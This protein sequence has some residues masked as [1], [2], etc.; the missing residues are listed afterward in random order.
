VVRTGNPELISESFWVFHQIR[1]ACRWMIWPDRSKTAKR[2]V[3]CINPISLEPFRPGLWHS[4]N[5]SSNCN[6]R[7]GY[8]YFRMLWR[9]LDAKS[10]PN[11]YQFN[12]VVFGKSSS[13]T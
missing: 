2:F 10:K 9:H 4:G 6:W 11:L 5:V 12:R 13:K 8:L 7:K 1:K 3:R